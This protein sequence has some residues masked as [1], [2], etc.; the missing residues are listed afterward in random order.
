MS[1]MIYLCKKHEGVQ[2]MTGP[3]GGCECVI[4]RVNRLIFEARR[5]QRKLVDGI[6]QHLAA[7]FEEA[8]VPQ[9]NK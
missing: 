4:C 3:D 1:S 6:N 9:R 7:A 5:D 2:I 8:G